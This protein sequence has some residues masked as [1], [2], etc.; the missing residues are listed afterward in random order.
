MA[1][2]SVIVGGV[3]HAAAT[4]DIIPSFFAAQE[5]ASLAMIVDPSVFGLL[6]AVGFFALATVRRNR[7]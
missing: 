5:N 3:A 6:G 7:T 2:L 1:G 4:T